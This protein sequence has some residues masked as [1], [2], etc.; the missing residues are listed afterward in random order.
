MEEW[1]GDVVSAAAELLCSDMRMYENTRAFPFTC[2]VTTFRTRFDAHKSGVFVCLGAYPEAEAGG[3]RRGARRGF[4]AQG[5]RTR[6]GG[7]RA[8]SEHRWP[9]YCDVSCSQT[10][11]QMIT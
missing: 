8:L 4:A 2:H 9:A 11:S 10:T 6:R 1:K 3:E 7:M 5:Q